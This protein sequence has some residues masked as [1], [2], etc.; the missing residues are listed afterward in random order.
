[1]TP[2]SQPRGTEAVTASDNKAA[3]STKQFFL[4]FI[5]GACLYLVLTSFSTRFFNAGERY[6]GKS[7]RRPVGM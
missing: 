2:A 1:M 3:G 7:F 5:V 4:F 6:V